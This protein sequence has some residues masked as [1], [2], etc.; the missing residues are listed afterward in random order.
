MS[1]ETRARV[2]ATRSW[3]D[4]WY[5]VIRRVIFKDS[6]LLDMMM[7]PE[8]ERKN[9][10]NFADKYFVNDVMPDS[11]VINENVRVI[12]AD[13]EGARLNIPQVRSRYIE[14]DVYVKDKEQR[15]YGRDGLSLRSR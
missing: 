6:M 9:V 7:I 5:D 4:N 2:W 13:T 3:D 10:I 14:F 11:L 8:K 15:T 12:Y 1:E